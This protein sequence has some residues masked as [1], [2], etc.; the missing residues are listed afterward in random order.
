MT[1]AEKKLVEWGQWQK[2]IFLADVG[3]CRK[4]MMYRLVTEGPEAMASARESACVA[5]KSPENPSAQTT[6]QWLLLLTKEAQ[7]VAYL[8]YV[9]EATLRECEERI[10]YNRNK[11]QSVLDQISSYITGRIH[12]RVGAI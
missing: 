1:E 9:F 6:E 7:K 3:Y 4:S 2:S 11:I 5:R 12:E 8:Y 10:G